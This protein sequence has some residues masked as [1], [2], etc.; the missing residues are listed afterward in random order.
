M[1]CIKRVKIQ[2]RE[3]GRTKE[4]KGRWKEKERGTPSYWLLGNTDRHFT[5]IKS[6]CWDSDCLLFIVQPGST[7]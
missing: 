1:E 6:K 7:W 2:E 3:M 4:A 5:C